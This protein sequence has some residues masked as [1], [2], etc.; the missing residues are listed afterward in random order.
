MSI[1][2]PGEW[3]FMTAIERASTGPALTRKAA[4]WPASAADPTAARSA[5]RY[6]AGKAGGTQR[7]RDGGPGFG[8]SHR[9]VFRRQ[10]RDQRAC[11]SNTGVSCDDVDAD[12]VG[13]R[14][15]RRYLVGDRADARGWMPGRC[16]CFGLPCT[17][18][19]STSTPC[20]R[21]GSARRLRRGFARRLGFAP[22]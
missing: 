15:G 14:H 4:A 19:V 8:R 21:P 16:R 5:N 20:A 10:A 7:A 18:H 9:D 12:D 11:R 1:E 17:R 13:G 6:D 2:Q 3:C 22:R